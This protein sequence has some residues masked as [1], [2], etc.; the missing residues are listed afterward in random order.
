MA[1]LIHVCRRD[2]NRI[3]RSSW[4]SVHPFRR[5]SGTIDFEDEC[6]PMGGNGCNNR[7]LLWW[8]CIPGVTRMFYSVGY[9]IFIIINIVSITISDRAYFTKQIIWLYVTQLFI[10]F[11]D[12]TRIYFHFCYE[13]QRCSVHEFL[14][15]VDQ[16]F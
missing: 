5:I 10:V 11:G 16:T 9:I 12:G 15:N 6:G 7:P 8:V 4:T 14:Y 2:C 13:T 3:V 1:A